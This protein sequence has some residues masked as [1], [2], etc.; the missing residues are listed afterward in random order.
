M[1]DASALIMVNYDKSQQAT[2][3]CPMQGAPL[4]NWTA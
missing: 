4:E 3:T 2:E 1:I